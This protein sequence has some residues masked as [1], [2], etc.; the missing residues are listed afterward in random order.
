MGWGWL[1]PRKDV[2]ALYCDNEAQKNDEQELY[3]QPPLWGGRDILHFIAPD[4]LIDFNF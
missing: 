4:S 2:Y 3:K 1:H